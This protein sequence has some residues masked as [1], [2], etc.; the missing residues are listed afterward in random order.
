MKIW[1][2]SDYADL[3]T[4]HDHDDPIFWTLME[5]FNDLTTNDQTPGWLLREAGDTYI[6]EMKK[7]E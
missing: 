6:I 7:E 2:I 3:N 4:L 5:Q 1:E